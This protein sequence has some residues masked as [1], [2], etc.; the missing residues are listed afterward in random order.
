[1]ISALEDKIS[2]GSLVWQSLI[3]ENGM[4]FEKL[5]DWKKKSH[6]FVGRAML[7]EKDFAEAISHFEQAL[8][9]LGG[10]SKDVGKIT[11]LLVFAKKQRTAE[12]R[13]EKST[14]SKA[15][16][17]SKEQQ[18]QEEFDAKEKTKKNNASEKKSSLLCATGTS[19]PVSAIFGASS[20]S[21]MLINPIIRDN[22]EASEKK[23]NNIHVEEELST[24]NWLV[25]GLGLL[26]LAAGVAFIFLKARR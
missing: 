24:M 20:F 11:E 25:G 5:M 26:G 15:F 13:R 22:I 17:V 12:L 4:T 19:A 16:Q 18:E 7:Q 3:S 9:L 10:Q 1:M 6:F 21:K 8:Q 23:E 14:W 2:Q